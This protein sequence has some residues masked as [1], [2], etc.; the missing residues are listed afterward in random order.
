MI[1][2][3]YVLISLKDKKFYIGYTSD[4]KRRI[5]QHNQGKTDS[6]KNRGPLKLIYFEGFVNKKDAQEKEKFYKSGRGHEVLKKILENTLK[7]KKF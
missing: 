2:F 6:L 3:V 1:Y 7:D 4:L 5:F